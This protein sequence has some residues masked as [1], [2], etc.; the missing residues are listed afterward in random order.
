MTTADA[1]PDAEAALGALVEKMRGSVAPDAAL[2]G[3]Y[4]GGAWLAERL[5]KRLAGSHP[6]GFIDVS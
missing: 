4:S 6:V 3:I 2:V 5:A 1:L